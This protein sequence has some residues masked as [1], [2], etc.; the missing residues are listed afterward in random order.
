MPHCYRIWGRLVTQATSMITQVSVIGMQLINAVA[1][2][3]W[4][5]P[6]TISPQEYIWI[7]PFLQCYM[8][9]HYLT[10]STIV[11][12]VPMVSKPLDFPL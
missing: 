7:S 6:G 12:N 8:F 10:I 1:A 4:G 11:L 3:A 9:M 5:T 2:E